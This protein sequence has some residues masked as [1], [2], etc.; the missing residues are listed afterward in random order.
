MPYYRWQGIDVTGSDKKGVLFATS[1][2]HLDRLLIKREIALLR[3]RQI[4]RWIKKPIT[5]SDRA[6]AFSQLAT[7]ID[8]GILL[9][10]ALD[11]VANQVD[12]VELQEI[13]HI[14]AKQVM[15]GSSFSAVLTDYPAVANH[16]IIQLI[17]AGEESGQ[18]AQVLDAVCTHLHMMQDFYRRIRAA[19][20]LPAITL[21]F[22]GSI[23]LLIFIVIIPRF[24]ALFTAMGTAIPPLTYY[25]I[26][27]SDFIR[28]W[29]M[30]LFITVILLISSILWRFTRQTAGRKILDIMLLRLPYIGRIMQYRFLAYSMQALSILLAGGIPL[31]QALT[32]VGTGNQNYCFKQQVRLLAMD[33]ET[34]SSLSDA[35][36]RHTAGIFSQ[37]IVAMVEVAE[38]SGR[39]PLLLDRVAQVYD[40]RVAERLAWLT[41]LI[42]PLIMLILGLLVAILILAVYG[43]ILSLSSAF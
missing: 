1:I 40:T 16:L 15:E 8:A 39:L 33:I 18:L 25:L 22:F 37:D 26:K 21:L 36:A 31:L 3:A 12:H 7:L 34:G 9:P 6:K 43:P 29:Y 13:M 19:L 30:V 4:K 14:I 20:L 38:A 28:S 41:L 24:I 42:Q 5:L 32:I 27:I 10:D 17:K 11:I 35:M 2:D 23:F